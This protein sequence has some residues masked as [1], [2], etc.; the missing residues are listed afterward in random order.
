LYSSFESLSVCANFAVE[1]KEKKIMIIKKI[2]GLL[3]FMAI[4]SSCDYQKQN[5]I[6]QKDLREGDEVVYGVHPDSAARQT[7]LKYAAKPEND[8]RAQ[9]I[10]EKFA[11]Q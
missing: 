3:F 11:K 4:L 6:E 2:F 9:K 10:R 5:K 8:A 7:K 1:L